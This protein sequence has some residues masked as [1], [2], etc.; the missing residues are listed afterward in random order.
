MYKVKIFFGSFYRIFCS[1]ALKEDIDWTEISVADSM[2]E[3]YFPMVPA[4]GE[5]VLIKS[6]RS[7]IYEGWKKYVEDKNS[8]LYWMIREIKAKFDI[9]K[10][11]SNSQIFKE[12]VYGGEHICSCMDDD[13]LYHV[14]DKVTSGVW[15]APNKD[16]VIIEIYDR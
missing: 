12:M 11:I 15:L 7:Q 16:Y 2:I 9:S 5:A 1:N 10:D 14:G 6:L 13:N 4:H 3:A 8:Q